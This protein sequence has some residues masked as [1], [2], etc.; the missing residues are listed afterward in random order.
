VQYWAGRENETA[1]TSE[2]VVNANS[3]IN[4]VAEM[5]EINARNM[6]ALRFRRRLHQYIRFHS[7]PQ[8]GLQLKNK[9]TKRLIDSCYRV[10][11]VPVI[12]DEGRPTGQSTSVWTEWD[13]TNDPSR[14][15]CASGRG[16]S[17]GSGSYDRTAHISPASSTTCSRGWRCLSR[18]TRRREEQSCTRF[19]LWGRLSKL[20]S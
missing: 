14:R 5:M 8:R 3:L 1:F 9:D 19:Y 11:T 7:A 2:R 12:D 18:S 13:A 17:P 6:V 15:S 10:K 20:R 16:L 4:E